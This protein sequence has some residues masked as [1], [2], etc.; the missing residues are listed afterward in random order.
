[1]GPRGPQTRAQV[2]NYSLPVSRG[3]VES[4]APAWPA[5]TWVTR[6]DWGS[7]GDAEPLE[8]SLEGASRVKVDI[9]AALHWGPGGSERPNFLKNLQNC[10]EQSS[11]EQLSD[12]S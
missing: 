12:V 6:D 3:P 9:Q 10:M 11:N 1:M 7:S 5:G 8:P 2:Q 4:L